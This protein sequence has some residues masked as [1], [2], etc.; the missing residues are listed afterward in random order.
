MPVAFIHRPGFTSADGGTDHILN[1]RKAQAAARNF[2]LVGRNLQHWQTG[3]LLDPDIGGALNAPQD[4][5][6][7]ISNPQ[8]GVELIAEYFHRDVTTHACN[9]FI[10]SH[11]DWLRELVGVTGQ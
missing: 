2:R 7:L 4:G 1:R 6:N 3:D 8:Q 10:E 9:E 11:L 5:G